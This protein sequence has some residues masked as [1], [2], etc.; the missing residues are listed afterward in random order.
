[1]KKITT[2]HI[3]I[4]GIIIVGATAVGYYA[5]NKSKKYA[6]VGT[7]LG[8]ILAGLVIPKLMKVE[9]KKGTVKVIV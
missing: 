1:M 7:V 3:L 4:G 6:I 5:N 8:V 2:K 9:E